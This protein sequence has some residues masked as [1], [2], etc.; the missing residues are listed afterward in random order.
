MRKQLLT[1]LFIF[2]SSL[3]FAQVGDIKGTILDG[4]SG[5]P[6]IGATVLVKGTTKGAIADLSGNFII[7]S[8]PSGSQILEF[9]YI[10]YEKLNV[11]VE[12]SEGLE[13]DI[14]VI[15]MESKAIGLDAVEVFATVVEDRRTPVAVSTIDAKTIDERYVGASL[16]QIAQSTPGIYAIQ[17]AGGYGDSE[18]Y[19]RGFD[20]TNVAFMVNGIPVNDME[21]G[22]MFWSN[23]AGLNEV[24][25]TMQVQRGLGASKLAISSIGGTVNMITKPA[26][27]REGGRVEYQVGTGSWNQRL[28]FTYHTGLSSNGWA[29]SFQ[30]SRT[31]TNS[32]LIGLPATDKG[33][34]MPGAFVDAWSYYVAISKQINRQHQVMFW[35]F[36]APVNR[37]TAWIADDATREAFNLTDPMVNNALGIYQGDIYNARQNKLHKP[38]MAMSHYWDIDENTNISTSVYLSLADV[39]STQPRDADNSLFF[40]ERFN[41]DDP[42]VD[43]ELAFTNE[44]LIDWDYFATINQDREVTVSFPNGDPNTP[45]VTGNACRFYLESRHNNHNWI[46]VIS[47]FRKRMGD[48]NVT[49]GVDYRHYKGL[50][51]AEVFETFQGDFVLNQSAF[52]DDFNKLKPNGVAYKGDRINYD[53]DGI[54]DW[55]AGFGQ[56]EYSFDKF[57]VFATATLTHSWYKRVGNFWNG[58]DIHTNNSL[59]ESETKAFTTVTTKAGVNY[60]PTNRHNFFVNGGFFTRPPFFRNALSDARYSNEFREGLTVEKIYAVEAGYGYRSPVLRVNVNAYF[61]N[62]KDRTTT[63]EAD[64]NDFQNLDDGEEVPFV[65]TGLRSEHKGIE[66][67]F[68]YNILPSLELNGFVS[69][70]DWKW[71]ENTVQE[72]TVS[73]ETGTVTQEFPLELKGLPVGTAAQTTAGFGFH[74]RGIRS[75][76]IGARVNYADD[77]AVRYNP[78]D[79]LEGFI[80]PEVIEEGFDDF[81]TVYI[82]AGRYFDLGENMNGR[83]SASVSNLFDVEYV[84]WASYFFGQ[85]QRAFG[86]PRTFTI[87]FMI[88]F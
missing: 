75:T 61:M 45:E 79:I 23:F 28:R 24:T 76:F 48:L 29:L 27:K 13:T 16:P 52:G 87:G 18:V 21:N 73:N 15:K 39:Y 1:T 35:G 9:S 63:F 74:F 26:E 68:V 67:D 60:R 6:L 59:G 77:I 3:L 32:E 38:L 54:V 2:L 57:D 69:L 7:K 53:Y 72:V 37:G 78:E 81:S 83:L 50:H 65:I 84:R 5:E 86:Y 14:G 51:Y 70:G 4:D 30:G 66:L 43:G 71:A 85:T 8:V 58:R 22:R 64:N 34:V 62:W 47:N 42:D 82:Y 33:S 49:G 20:Q 40:P 41:I 12:I 11:Q 10:S 25:R 46:G 88:E 80:T 19:I 44:N 36:G 31:T 55:L 17:G 56:A